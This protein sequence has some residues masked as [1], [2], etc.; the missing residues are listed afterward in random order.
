MHA[1]V[2]MYMHVYIHACIIYQQTLTSTLSFITV[3][4]T[5]TNPPVAEPEMQMK[6]RQTALIRNSKSHSQNVNICTDPNADT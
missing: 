2:Y 4:L 5:M 6:Y 3:K 1:C